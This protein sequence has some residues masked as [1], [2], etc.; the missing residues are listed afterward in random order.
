M[1]ECG[2]S[3]PQKTFDGMSVEYKR[4]LW[5]VIAL[6]ATMFFVE[7]AAGQLAGS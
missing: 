5:V 3:G 4:I 6:N 1:S 2:C 7:M